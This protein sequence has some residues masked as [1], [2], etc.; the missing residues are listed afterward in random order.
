MF[1]PDQAAWNE[2]IDRYGPRIIRWCRAWGL[3]D[4]DALDVSQTVLTRLA[5]RLREFE[6]ASSR[7]FRG[8]LRKLVHDLLKDA[9]PRRGR[10]VGGGERDVLETLGT[11]EARQ[12]LIQRLEEEY[13]LELLDAATKRVGQRVAPHTWEAYRLTAVEGL[14]GAETAARLGMQIAN[15][16][17]AK[18]SVIRMLR[19][20]IQSL[21]SLTS[22]TGTI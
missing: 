5:I 16:Y 2:F 9:L 18:K 4:A 10:F 11:L 8:L 17:V 15:V 7:S 6:Y 20:E 14:S 12:D 19:E 3:Q 13:D 22:P 21:E 1:P